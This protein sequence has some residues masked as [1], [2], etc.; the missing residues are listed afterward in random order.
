MNKFAPIYNAI[1]DE[2][3][4]FAIQII[5][6]ALKKNPLSND[7]PTLHALKALSL[8]RSG[9]YQEGYNLAYSVKQMHPTEPYTVQAL[10]LTFKML[11]MYDDIIDLYA[12]AYEYSPNEEWANHWF[13]GLARKGDYKA[14]QQAS[15]KINKEF[16]SDKYYYWVVV[17]I[18]MQ[19]KEKKSINPKLQL[20]LAER[21]MDKGL[22]ESR[23][24]NYEIAQL[25]L[26]ILKD[27][28]KYKEA[29]ELIQNDLK[30]VYK[31]EYERKKVCIEYFTKLED[32]D[33]IA[34]YSMELLRENPEDW[35]VH[36]AFLH[37][38]SNKSV[39][40]VLDFYKELQDLVGKD[41]YLKRGP[42]L[43]EF[44]YRA[45][46]ELFDGIVDFIS[47]YLGNFGSSQSCFDDLYP[48]LHSIP[49]QYVADMVD[50]IY[51]ALDLKVADIKIKQVKM[52]ITC[53][54]LLCFF[55]FEMNSEF[56][57]KNL[58]AAYS[59]SLKIKLT[60]TKE[61][62]HGDDYLIVAAHYYLEG[63]I[64]D[65][66][67]LT[68]VYN[69]IA[70][71]E[72][73]LVNSKYNYII[74]LLLARLYF[75][76][77]ASNRALDLADTLD[78]K[79]VQL[80]TIS[81]LYTDGLEHYG[82]IDRAN[83]TFNNALS[84]YLRNDIET[85]EMI[86]QAF[87]F[88][89]FSK[90]PE[91][92]DFKNR[93]T[94]SVQRAITNR[95]ILRLEYLSPS[96]WLQMQ[97]RMENTNI[98]DLSPDG[99]C[100]YLNLDDLYDNRDTSLVARFTAGNSIFL[101]D[102]KG[103]TFPLDAK[104]PDHYWMKLYTFIPMI[105]SQ[106]FSGKSSHASFNS[107]T[108]FD[109][110]LQTNSMTALESLGARILLE[111][112]KSNETTAVDISKISDLHGELN[113]QLVELQNEINTKSF[114]PTASFCKSTT[115]LLEAYNIASIFTVR[116]KD[117]QWKGEL[118]RQLKALKQTLSKANSKINAEPV[119]NIKAN[120]DDMYSS[121]GSTNTA[122]ELMKRSWMI[123]I[124]GFAGMVDGRLGILASF[125]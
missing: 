44:Y 116:E 86:L 35:S 69:A 14:L 20:T 118:T 68:A 3:Y 59:N 26:D 8:A 55:R 31:V 107:V 51:K 78:I 40:N 93:L 46:C 94:F 54:K 112:Y 63:Y 5:D 32:Y 17:S 65:K 39:D 42:Y 100:P 105:L 124:S 95:Q 10:F 2:N 24:M 74:T 7:V 113:N 117:R 125:K 47:A 60:Q 53:I 25:H 70:I 64:A 67:N 82:N 6:K 103:E 72:Y 43:G 98:E 121:F 79:Q 58:I 13:M 88:G 41:K 36:E 33:N 38:L 96:N 37:A 21:M 81:Y 22:K 57:P 49:E 108:D 16:K 18:Y 27:Q 114:I 29:L 48:R 91:F 110:F 1:D 19:S 77:G 15:V 99:T 11:K 30:S 109:E 62:Q 122:A 83:Y 45:Q 50:R 89:T 28:G 75:E 80:D 9:N 52:N 12:T 76:I 90:I 73:G 87:K 102:V 66:S 120:F 106:M 104:N 101:Q 85:P 92:I 34:S 4:R 71:L 56:N 97:D 119:T 115:L 111:F 61:R 123:T 23:E 84:I